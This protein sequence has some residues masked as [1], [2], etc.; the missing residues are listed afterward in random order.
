MKN[1][2][3]S[4]K[5][6]LLQNTHY[7]PF[8][9]LLILFKLINFHSLHLC[10]QGPLKMDPDGTD[11]SCESGKR[12]CNKLFHTCFLTDTYITLANVKCR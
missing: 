9:S 1:K 11:V 5:K 10:H 3:A 12:G 2:R 7:L 4:V 8:I 6:D